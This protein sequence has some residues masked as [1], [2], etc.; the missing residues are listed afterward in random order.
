VDPTIHYQTLEGWGT[1]LAWWAEAVGS[2]P[3]ANQRAL[4]E[5]A[6][7]APPNLDPR[8]PGGLGLNVARYNFGADT[9]D[10]NCPNV[11]RPFGSIPSY[12]PYPGPNGFDWSQDP[13]Q[14]QVLLDVKALIPPNQA[15]FEGFANSAPVWM[16]KNQFNP[17]NN[18]WGPCTQGYG[19]SDNT[20]N[21]L[22]SGIDPVTHVSYEQDYANYL[23]TIVQHFQTDPAF[24]NITF[25]TVEPFNEPT[26]AWWWSHPQ[27]PKPH[28]NQEGMHV[29]QGQ[30]YR[31]INDLGAALYNQGLLGSTSISADDNNDINKAVEDY[32]YYYH[33]DLNGKGTALAYISQ[34]NTHSYNGDQRNAFYQL[35]QYTHSLLGQQIPPRVWMS[36][37]TTNGTTS[38]GPINYPCQSNDTTDMAGALALS[39]Q[40]LTDMHYMHPQAWSYWQSVEENENACSGGATITSGYG[41]LQIPFNS[42][43]QCYQQFAYSKQYYAMG[44]YSEFIRPGFQLIAIDNA[45]SLA[46]YN[47]SLQRLEIVT[48][49]ANSQSMNLTFDLSKFNNITGSVTPYQTAG[50]LNPQGSENLNPLQN[51]PLNNN[52]FSYKVPAKSITTF[53]I[54]G[55]S[56]FT[57]PTNLLSNADFETGSLSPWQGEWNPSDAGV[58]NNFPY[59]GIYDA[60]L[61]P[62]SFQDVAVFQTITAPNDGQLHTYILTAYAATNIYLGG[63]QLGVDVDQQQQASVV[64]KTNTGYRYYTISFTASSGQTIKVWYYANKASGWATLDDVVLSITS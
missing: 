8:N 56:G 31:I 61:H 48:T 33:Q 21:N 32:N 35:G 36:E 42:S 53:D 39:C 5:K 34:I 10:N 18:T 26:S 52:L 64:I 22:R 23:A 63:V 59:S 54:S 24:G 51:I 27:K 17:N 55:V 16:L 30:Q 49:N 2:W 14:R 7:F 43:S 50:S 60:Y 19:N 3:D 12:Q 45:N 44:Q 9:P 62:N 4:L 46:A 58:E 6:L 28:P 13:A 38:L 1:S 40:I 29:S 37:Y 57:N 25:R 47:Q 11:F 15:I 20:T 41:L